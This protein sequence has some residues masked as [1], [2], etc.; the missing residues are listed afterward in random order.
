MGDSLTSDPHFKMMS[1]KLVQ[2][3]YLPALVIHI[4]VVSLFARF[5]CFVLFF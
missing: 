5:F 3:Q 4:V 2:M 1:I